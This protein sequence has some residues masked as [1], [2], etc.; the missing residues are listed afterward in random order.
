VHLQRGEDVF[1]ALDV[2][3]IV[4]D[5]SQA[6]SALMVSFR[7]NNAT[8]RLFDTTAPGSSNALTLSVS[9]QLVIQ[10]N[11]DGV[12]VYCCFINSPIDT[13]SSRSGVPFINFRPTFFVADA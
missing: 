12:L 11:C 4:S 8:L 7:V 5:E 13:L 3:T 10:C 6:S 2:L 9:Q 1:S